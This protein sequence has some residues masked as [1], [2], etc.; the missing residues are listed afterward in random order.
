MIFPE[1]FITGKLV[2]TE[3]DRELCARALVG[4]DC[5]YVGATPPTNFGLGMAAI[6]EKLGVSATEDSLTKYAI[7]KGW[8]KPKP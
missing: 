2:G 3:T 8:L 7:E 5:C 6:S 4:L 1:I